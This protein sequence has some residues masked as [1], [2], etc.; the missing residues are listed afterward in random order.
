MLHLL[1]IEWLKVKNYRT[2]WILLLLIVVSI[3]AF[4]YTI[5][6]ITDN[7]F[8]QNTRQM[9]EMILGR[10][11]NFP[12]I[13]QTIGWI[14]GLML[15]IPA[16]LIITITTNEFTYKTHRQNIID[17]WART[18]FIL[19]K[20]IEVV[21]LAAFTTLLVFLSTI[22]IGSL[23]AEAGATVDYLDNIK[24]L[25]YF[26]MQA[27]SY[28]MLAFLL[29]VLVKRAG[30]VMGIFFL[31]SM[32]AEQ[33][34]VVLLQRFQNDIGRFLPLETADRLILN[35]FTRIFMKPDALERW[36]E[37]LPYF[38]TMSGIY[39]AIYTVIVIWYFRKKDL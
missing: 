18:E 5:Y 36:Q 8:G 19:V 2:F 11:F 27:L 22:W 3:P 1:K 9:K 16:L 26:F 39:F 31:Y 28:I 25:G 34:A 21:L 10:P 33:L 20:M 17:G 24:N 4:N 37:N 14:S 30:L 38:L 32:V 29:S 15:F 12:T 23:T 13:W 6:D 35:P 7:S